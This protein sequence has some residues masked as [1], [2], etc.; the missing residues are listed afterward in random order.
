MLMIRHC[1]TGPLYVNTYLVYDDEKKEAFV[2]DPG[3]K[4]AQLDSFIETHKLNLKYVIL[5]HGHADHIGG[6]EHYKEKYGAQLLANWKEKELLSNADYNSSRGIFGKPIILVAD[7]WLNDGETMEFCGETVKFIHTPGHSPGGQCI[8][9]NKWL[10][11]GD[12]LFAGSVG[13]TDFPL[14]ST[15]DLFDSI[16]SKLFVL[17]PETEVYPGH[18]GFST[19]GRE[20]QYNPFF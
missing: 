15:P 1:Y 3:D 18:E 8:L 7:K 2:I 16:R 20:I 9:I 5:T 12:T 19:I 14:C 13:R 4:N 10:F 6:V 17:D 11:S